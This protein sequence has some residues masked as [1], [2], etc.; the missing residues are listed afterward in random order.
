MALRF[1]HVILTLFLI[2]S[3]LAVNCTFN[4]FI[5][6]LMNCT[7]LC[8]VWEAGKKRKKTGRTR[9]SKTTEEAQKDVDPMLRAQV[10]SQ[11]SPQ[12]KAEFDNGHFSEKTGLYKKA[13]KTACHQEH[14]SWQ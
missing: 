14:T 6:L 2:V 3:I 8:G 4:Y 7:A 1:S 11:S 10:L 12:E 5:K 9:S 13:D